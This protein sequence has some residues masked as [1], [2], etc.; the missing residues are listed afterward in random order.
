MPTFVILHSMFIFSA[1]TFFKNF[2][3]LSQSSVLTRHVDNSNMENMIRCVGL[4]LCIHIGIWGETLTATLRTVGDREVK[5]GDPVSLECFGSEGEL[6]YY[7]KNKVSWSFTDMNKVTTNLTD[8]FNIAQS[9]KHEFHS[10]HYV[11]DYETVNDEFRYRLNITSVRHSDDGIYSCF[12]LGDNL[13]GVEG[14]QYVSAKKTIRVTVLN[15][16]QKMKLEIRTVRGA[17]AT[18]TI[19]RY[20]TPIQINPGEHRVH[21][22]AFG[23]NPAPVMG[24]MYN[25]HKYYVM[26]KF[27]H[28]S[29]L[30]K[31]QYTGDLEV[32]VT[33]DAS[34]GTEQTLT[35]TANVPNKQFRTAEAGLK[36]VV[37][38]IKPEI[39]CTNITVRKNYSGAKITCH[40]TEPSA[41]DAIMCNKVFWELPEVQTLIPTKGGIAKS[42]LTIDEF[43]IL[44]GSCYRNTEGLVAH[45]KISTVL[46]KHF[47]TIFYLQ[48]NDG[49]NLYR[50]PLQITEEK[51][52][53]AANLASAS[54]TL[55]LYVT[56]CVICMLTNQF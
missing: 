3:A 35:C 51:D 52:I 6:Q 12:L 27:S 42:R 7:I 18:S 1:Q 49:A 8:G 5:I 55:F 40:I 31:M 13:Y 23:S 17:V 26:P 54:Q 48:Y 56:I 36:L 44:E 9:V 14:L 43:G 41:P 24:L 15:P 25:E 32:K 19:S 10:G 45:L 30:K 33:I 20:D 2:V 22:E 46:Q 16:V 11:L 4:I 29:A 50:T 34:F 21:C 53:S 38:T 47:E 39:S 37:S 28:S